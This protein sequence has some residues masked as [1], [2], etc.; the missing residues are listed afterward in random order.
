MILGTV[1]RE[2]E[3]DRIVGLRTDQRVVDRLLN[4]D[5][6]RALVEQSVCIDNIEGVLKE[7]A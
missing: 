6:C 5:P 2:R 4:V 3:D 7:G 1:G